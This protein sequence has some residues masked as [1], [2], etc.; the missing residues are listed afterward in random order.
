MSEHFIITADRGHLHIYQH[1]QARGQMTPTMKEVQAL[2][3][4]GGRRSYT[5]RD[6]DMAGRFQGSRNP[7]QGSGAPTARTGMSIDER[8]P[9]QEEEERR[10]TRDICHA[11][12]AFLQQRP[13]ATWDFAGAPAVHNSVLEALSPQTRSRLRQSVAKD[14]VNQPV[15]DLAG[16]FEPARANQR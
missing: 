6:T 8:L 4:P 12:D 10:Q 1:Q 13:N 11:I 15:A 3:F 9:M 2:D 16:H 7:A 14:L 5:D